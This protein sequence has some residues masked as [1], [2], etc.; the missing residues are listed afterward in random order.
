MPSG[1]DLLQDGSPLLA[2][3]EVD[4]SACIRDRSLEHQ[5]EKYTAQAESFKPGES[6]LH[7]PFAIRN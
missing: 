1:T 3:R 7:V 6:I 5:K 4:N 2:I